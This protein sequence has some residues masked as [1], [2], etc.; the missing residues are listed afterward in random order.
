MK[1]HLDLRK[2]IELAGYLAVVMAL[3]LVSPHALILLP[4]RSN[5]FSD[6]SICLHSILHL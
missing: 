2:G 6:K 1:D 3:M 4:I 5:E